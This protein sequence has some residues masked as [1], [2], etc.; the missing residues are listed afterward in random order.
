MSEKK[1]DA[2]KSAEESKG[3]QSREDEYLQR[4]RELEQREKDLT[5]TLQ[6]L[7]AEFENYK[8]RADK[9]KEEFRKYAK[10][11]IIEKL[12]PVIDNFE[13][14]LKNKDKGGHFVK[15]IEMVYAEMI[16]LLQKEGVARISAEGKKADP[17]FHEVLMT[18]KSEKEDGTILE[19]LQRGYML[20]DK[21]L[22]Y[23]KV[24]VA[25]NNGSQEAK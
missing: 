11:G 24:K 18:E 4:I 19:E 14:A 6:R 10:A 17:S 3:K 16:S 25:K 15:G 20:D 9:E 2:R 5:E 7:Q 1:K 12:L 23:S 21:V 8:K 22:R 13:I